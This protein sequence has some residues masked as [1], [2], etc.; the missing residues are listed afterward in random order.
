MHV[1]FG[2]KLDGPCHPQTAGG[3]ASA[4]GEPVVGPNGFL[5]LLESA[6]GLAGPNTPAA[7]RIARYQGRLRLLDNGTRFYSRSFA[8][9]AWATAKQILAW[10]D[11]LYAS[12]WKGQQIDN[13]GPRL[14]T[15]ASVEITEGQPLGK[16]TGER[17]HAIL[18]DLR[19]GHAI[20]IETIDVVSSEERFPLMWQRLFTRLRTS[21]ITIRGIEPPT[22]IGDSDLVAIQCALRGGKAAKFVGDGSFILFDADDEWQAADA[23][24]AWLSSGDNQQTVIVRGTGCPSLDA[25][26]RRLG[27][28]RPGWTETSP[29]R[30]ALQVL[31][32]ALEMLWE[33]LEPAR[34][35]E[36]LSLPRSPLPRF[37]ARRFAHA[38][39]DEPGIGGA[40]WIEAWQDCTKDLEGWRRIDG[41]DDAA[42]KKEV[43]KAQGEWRFWLEPQRFRRSEGIP[44]QLV[45]DVCHRI[46]QWAGGVASDNDYLFLTAA[47]HSSALSE[48]IA[49]LGAPYIPAIQLGRIIDAVTAEGVSAPAATEEAAPWSV[50]DAPG[51]VWGTADT[52]VW[53]GFSGDVSSPPRQPWSTAEIAALASVD[54]HVEPIENIV[55]REAASWRQA[56]L[57]ARC[58][59]IL[60]MPRRLRGET[61]TPHPLW[62]EIFAQLES[63]QAVTKARIRAQTIATRETAHLGDRAI[64]RQGISPLALPTARRRWVV[65]ASTI[66]RRPI[67]SITSIKTM[68]E[69]PLAWALNYGAHVRPGALDVLPDDANLIGILAH[70][71][72]EKLFDQR[73]SWSP[74]EAASAAAKMFDSLAVQTAA[75]LLRPGYAVEYERA[76]ARV[77][78]SIRLLVQMIADA[79]LTVRGVEEEVVVTFASG[80]DFGGYLD[81]VLEDA[82]G[83]SVVLD[84]KW[85]S[86]DKY[87]REEVQEGRAFQL[88]AYTWLEEQAGRTS[89][90]A[91]YF[92]LR[93]QSLLFTD[94]HPFS[95]AHHVPGSDLKQTWATLRAA[96]DHRMGQLEH[97]D[98]LV[99]GVPAGTDETD[100]DPMPQVEPGC[101]FCDYRFLCGASIQGGAR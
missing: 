72:V 18:E 7:V 31:P 99:R 97:G 29:Q 5:G 20:P 68:I 78:D 50:V 17:L 45:Q 81:L 14:E 34:V 65:P 42:I 85:S 46:A 33:P 19:I 62:H 16:S 49:A 91:G 56:L 48:S 57:G 90:G 77:S 2:W 28:P 86:R 4:I 98:V 38:L 58:R 10:R 8:R 84:L 25:A 93:Q 87:R 83:R 88:A 92:M 94:P 95:A 9:D 71:V 69:C 3:A 13:A 61:A 101:R 11:E 63:L 24:A 67:E 36:F 53:W 30:S 76:K 80:Q 66:T 1:V 100:V 82:I 47:A 40:R 59:A 55:L 60:V 12:G 23:V 37:V 26:C 35:L 54:A 96:Y 41:L 64:K 43:E 74:D 70:A 21:G 44:V 6:L 79:G 73:R 27:L 75:P 15:M 52:V 32:L 39:M 89:L 22:Q 51:Q